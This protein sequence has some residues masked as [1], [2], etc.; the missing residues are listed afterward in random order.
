MLLAMRGRLRTGGRGSGWA[1]VTKFSF[2]NSCSSG[3]TSHCGSVVRRAAAEGLKSGVLSFVP[4]SN[5]G[6]PMLLKIPAPL[7]AV[8]LPKEILTVPVPPEMGLGPLPPPSRM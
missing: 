4:A 8:T 6:K 2:L 3:D 7:R 5:V 1:T